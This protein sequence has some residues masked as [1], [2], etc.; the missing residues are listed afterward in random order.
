[1]SQTRPLPEVVRSIV[2][3]WQSTSTLS[4]VSFRSSSM[5]STP[6]PITDSMAAIEFSG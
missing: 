4:F 3:S 2:R 5:M 6:M 1:M